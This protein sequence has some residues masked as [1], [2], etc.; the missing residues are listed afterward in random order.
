MS[1]KIG[2][3]AVYIS[4]NTAALQTGLARASAM[5]A[6]FAGGAARQMAHATRAATSFARDVSA[7]AGGNLLA[8]GIR[9]AAAS[10]V[11]LA[12]AAEVSAMKF[13][14][15][16]GSAKEAAALMGDL[17]DFAAASP[18]SLADAQRHA[19]SLVSKDVARQ[20]VVPTLKALTEVSMGDPQVLKS[21][22]TA[23]GQVMATGRLQGDEWNQIANTGTLTFKDLAKVLKVDQSEVKKLIEAGKVGFYDLQLAIKEATSEGGRFAGMTARYAD[24]Y[25]G[26]L[27]KLSDAWDEAKREMGKGLIAG[28]DLKAGANGAADLVDKAK[29]LATVLEGV[30]RTLKTMVGHLAD[31]AGWLYRMGQRAAALTMG[32][33]STVDAARRARANMTWQ[34]TRASQLRGEYGLSEADAYRLFDQQTIYLDAKRAAE[35]AAESMKNLPGGGSY[36]DRI[37]RANLAAAAEAEMAAQRRVMDAAAAESAKI[38][39][40]GDPALVTRGKDG[41]PF[42]PVKPLLDPRLSDLAGKL[43]ERFMDPAKKLAEE[44]AD[45]NAIRNAG[46]IDP[47]VYGRALGD[48][49]N[50]AGFGGGQLA[51]GVELGSQQLASMVAR[52]ASGGA[53]PTDVPTLLERIR[54]LLE[55]QDATAKQIA[56]NTGA[57]PPVL[58]TPE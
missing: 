28:L 55:S 5:T 58:N 49:V 42:T 44:L 29:K 53:G 27:D 46:R 34:D 43:A 13:D 24:T 35:K 2:D 41:K 38:V 47:D 14:V 8:G 45:L 12:K 4:A 48:L 51:A 9:E 40:R 54:S 33:V 36:N 6:A 56:T 26:R 39:A 7:V 16:L 1:T 57:K 3:L 11:E 15:L 32:D 37:R 30:A 10:A 50:G 18:V 25:A 52:A 20:D 17:K 21:W 22:V 31:G 23:Y 19:V